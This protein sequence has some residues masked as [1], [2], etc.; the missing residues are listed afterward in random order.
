MKGNYGNMMRN[1][2]D[3]KLAPW[4]KAM[5]KLAATKGKRQSYRENKYTHKKSCSGIS[6]R[7]HLKPTEKAESRV[8]P[9][10][11]AETWEKLELSSG[12][13]PAI[14]KYASSNEMRAGLEC[15]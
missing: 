15:F 3:R 10:Q 11:S 7:R 5:T 12:D 13:I 8:V 14:L 1:Y 9:V 2:D 6:R 4:W